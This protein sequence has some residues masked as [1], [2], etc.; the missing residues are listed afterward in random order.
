ML[1]TSHSSAAELQSDIFRFVQTNSILEGVGPFEDGYIYPIPRIIGF[2][3]LNDNRLN[4][5]SDIDEYSFEIVEGDPSIFEISGGELFYKK[6]FDYEKQSVYPL[7]IRVTLPMPNGSVLED[8]FNLEIKDRLELD[9]LNCSEEESVPFPGRLDPFP[10]LKVIENYTDKNTFFV[11][12]IGSIDD[13]QG[14]LNFINSADYA[15]SIV[16]GDSEH[17][18]LRL[19]GNLSATSIFDYEEKSSYNLTIRSTRRDCAYL[20]ETITVEIEDEVNEEEDNPFIPCPQDLIGRSTASGRIEIS[21]N[22]I[23]ESYNGVYSSKGE[24]IGQL[25][26]Q[27]ADFF[28]TFYDYSIVG[29]EGSENFIINDQNYLV[30]NED[31]DYEEKSFYVLTI[32][33]T[34]PHDGSFIEQDIFIKV[35][36][37]A[38]EC[39]INNTTGAGTLSLSD[40][41]VPINH[42]EVK[43]EENT[44]GWWNVG[45]FIVDG[46]V[47]S[48]TEYDF[49]M[50]ELEARDTFDISLGTLRAIKPLTEDSYTFTVIAQEPGCGGTL[51]KTFTINTQERLDADKAL[52]SGN[53]TNNTADGLIVLS[54]NVAP[55]NWKNG[56]IGKLEKHKFPVGYL[57]VADSIDD[58]LGLDFE[59]GDNNV[60][61][62]SIVGG[63]RFDFE[64]VSHTSF[65]G[66][67]DVLQTKFPLDYET[68]SSYSVTVRA[69]NRQNSKFLERTFTIYVQDLNRLEPSVKAYS[70][71]NGATKSAA[72]NISL[73]RQEFL[74]T[75]GVG[76]RIV[77]L[78]DIDDGDYYR[79]DYYDLSLVSGDTSNFEIR[80]NRSLYA[81]GDFDFDE[82]SSYN[83][84]IR[85]TEPD[86]DYLEQEFQIQVTENVIPG[87]ITLSNTK[88]N[89][90]DY[91]S[92]GRLVGRLDVEDG[93]FDGLI[94]EYSLLDA[95]V[96]FSL[97]GNFLM[98]KGKF[99]AETQDL[100]PVTV[101]ATDPNGEFLDQVFIL[102]VEPG[103]DDD[104]EGENIARGT[105]TITDNS[106]PHNSSLSRYII[107][108]VQVVDGDFARFRY[109][110]S[111]QSNNTDLFEISS[112]GTLTA[113]A[114]LNYFEKPLHQIR[115]RAT[116][117][118][119]D[120]LES[121]LTILV[122]NP[123]G[124]DDGLGDDFPDPSD[125][126]PD[127]RFRD[128]NQIISEGT[129]S[130]DIATYNTFEPIV[131]FNTSQKMDN[132]IFSLRGPKKIRRFFAIRDNKLILKR[133]LK[134]K[135]ARRLR[136][137]GV[138]RLRVLGISQSR[139]TSTQ[140]II[141][142]L[143]VN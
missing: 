38:L 117:P 30:A 122:E 101:R 29:G 35:I 109:D 98:A 27:C 18:N 84:G 103:E 61:D 100:Y 33:A 105:L 77:S 108:F 141:L 143:P 31:L 7:R 12:F 53:G 115:V 86:G 42:Q 43:G 130:K 9:E 142:P 16:S 72:G 138:M 3:M 83:I 21:S 120:Y 121:T 51:Q 22:I 137:K 24:P 127:V 116:E 47:D 85:A 126:K 57:A 107:G 19:D 111:L 56:F 97:A 131:S 14:G 62:Y 74:E 93:L 76:E 102:E 136:R 129:I 106:V 80:G 26:T 55:E 89:E 37:Y 132:A 118:D 113:I 23:S 69:T 66:S 82:K 15:Y 70:L 87:T 140:T 46:G 64:I 65:D 58:I 44:F 81:V 25:Q 1:F 79:N 36:D 90:G 75:D 91:G 112:S 49:E 20:E 28:Y 48:A 17:F 34:A 50:L 125:S 32:R 96:Q 92:E 73:S 2:F 52:D 10:G 71:F 68:K 13:S 11:A 8:S 4:D 6:A 110:Y 63:D 123:G 45:A 119:G 139:E 59:K 114:P 133:P 95:D 40:N 135:F 54:E 60:Y 67:Y 78:I 41:T 94:F 39:S 124:I 5:D 99:H 134:P 128:G 88:I 104:S